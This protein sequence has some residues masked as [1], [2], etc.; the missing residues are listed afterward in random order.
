MSTGRTALGGRL[1]FGV[2]L[3]RLAIAHAL[4]VE[5][6]ENALAEPLFE[7]EQDL[8]PGEVDAAVLG[9]M[10]DPLDSADV[11][12]AVEPDVGGSPRRADQALVFVDPQ[13]SRMDGDDAGGHADHVDRPARV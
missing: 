1:W 10:P 3:G 11:L 6:L 13:R 9:Q 5:R 12:F 7:L 2:R 8:D 4:V